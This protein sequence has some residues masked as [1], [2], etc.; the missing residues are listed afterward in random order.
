[1]DYLPVELLSAIFS[2]LGYKDLLSV[3]S[4]TQRWRIA[5]LHDFRLCQRLFLR[6]TD[7][8]VPEVNEATPPPEKRLTALRAHP[9]FAVLRYQFGN[10]PETAKLMGVNAE[11]PFLNELPVSKNFAFI[12]SVTKVEIGVHTNIG[13][14]SLLPMVKVHVMNPCGVTVEDVFV[15]LADE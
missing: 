2:S 6:R 15:A 5:V 3:S 8:Y 10:A 11:L 4:T 7:Q 9:V 1:M 13:A 12:P 14:R